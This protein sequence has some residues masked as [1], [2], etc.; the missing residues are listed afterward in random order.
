MKA[1]ANVLFLDSE[2]HKKMSMEEKN[3]EKIFKE[4]GEIDYK[5]QV[6][7]YDQ[8]TGKADV[9]KLTSDFEPPKDWGFLDEVELIIEMMP[10]DKEGKMRARIDAFGKMIA[11][12][13]FFESGKKAVQS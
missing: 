12:S 2:L 7:E 5:V 3:G 13:R 11:K 9:R 4:T 6:V 10:T 8:M 1:K